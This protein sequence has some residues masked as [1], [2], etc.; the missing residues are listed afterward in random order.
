MRIVRL[1]N[2]VTPRSGG[3]RTALRELGVGYAAAGH[4]PILVVPGER[5]ADE[6]H[7]Q[8]RVV[9]L[10]GPVVP[11]LGGY[12]V[13]L[14]KK[15]LVRTLTELK[16]DSLEVSDRTTLRWTGAWA[17][18]QR[19]GSVM[20]SHESLNGLLR[21]TRLP[22][23]VRRRL[24]TSL[25]RATA[26]AYDRIVC[27]TE[28]AA[29]EFHHAGAANVVQVPLGVDLDHFHPG[30]RSAELRTSLAE[31]DEI[32]LVCATRLSVEK[33]PQR[34]LTT[35]AALRARGVPARLVIVGDGPLRTRLTKAAEGLP[36]S[37]TGWISD[38][39]ELAA[40]QATADVVLAPGPIETFGLAALEAS[41]C[42]TPVVASASS[43][44]SGVL[45]SAGASA[46]GEDFSAEVLSLLGRPDARERAR[47]R[48]EEF[49]WAAAVRGFLRVHEDL[50]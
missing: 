42:G 45:G 11:G 3:L 23:G 26:R 8:G 46:P 10:P 7:P 40:L 19:I 5:A 49:S 34:A 24:A 21:V 15:E 50:P 25:N 22:G 33:R 16:P 31:P 29:D 28:W 20:V 38:R 1:A 4:E 13:L 6:Q 39:A 32:L 48:A 2:F 43:A 17:Q 37:F 12:R 14:N 41:A 44:L 35:L 36:V 47:R 27:T 30:R 18:E 9:T